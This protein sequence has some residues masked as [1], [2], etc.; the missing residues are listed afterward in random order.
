MIYTNVELH[1]WIF[2]AKFQNHR[3]SGSWEYEFKLLRFLLFIGMAAVLVMWPRPFIQTF[4]S[5]TLIVPAVSEEMM[6][7]H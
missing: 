6:F 7:V 3:A 2:L 5:L 1:S 4:V